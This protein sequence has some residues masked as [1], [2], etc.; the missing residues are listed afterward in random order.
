MPMHDE[1]S[2]SVLDA[3]GK[4]SGFYAVLPNDT[5]LPEQFSAGGS[6][7]TVSP[8]RALCMAVLQ[9]GIYCATLRSGTIGGS[10]PQRPPRKVRSDTQQQAID[11][12]TRKEEDA[13]EWPFSFER[14]CHALGLNSDA[15]RER[16]LAE[17]ERL[18]AAGIWQVPRGRNSRARSTAG[19]RS[20]IGSER[21]KRDAKESR[22][23]YWERKA[24]K[25]AAR[26][27][28]VP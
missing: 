22:D 13:V 5:V 15:V 23:R 3:S 12:I 9:D 20:R 28:R 10:S 26:K 4:G 19:S 17:V 24:E 16:V 18:R 2:M 7:D 1:P 21:K 6:A 25:K 8:E 11:W 27:K 14:L